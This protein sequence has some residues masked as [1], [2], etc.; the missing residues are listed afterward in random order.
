MSR[1]VAVTIVR[2]IT[3]KDNYSDKTDSE[4]L[5]MFQEDADNFSLDDWYW[6]D[7]STTLEVF[8]TE[9]VVLGVDDET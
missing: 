5:E 1:T 6:D 7:E 2:T 4:I 8:P 9:E 3:L